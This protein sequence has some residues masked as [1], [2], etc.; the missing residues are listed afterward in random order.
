[1]KSKLGVLT[2]FIPFQVLSDT[3]QVFDN[4]G[5][6]YRLPGRPNSLQRFD[7]ISQKNDIYSTSEFQSYTGSLYK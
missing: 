1:M 2:S 3:E 7:K 5:V 4:K 6:Y